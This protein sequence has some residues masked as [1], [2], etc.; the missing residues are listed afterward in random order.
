VNAP[1]DALP[2]WALVAAVI[3]GTLL[4]DECG[5]RLGRRRGRGA[6]TDSVE[7]VGTIVA[8]E[9]GLLAFLLAFSFGIVA[10]RFDA[11]RHMVLDEANAIGTTFLRAEMLPPAER[12][13]V[14]HLLRR[15]AAVRLAATTGAPIDQVLQQSEQIHDQLWRAAVAAAAADARALPTG[16]FIESLNEVIDLHTARV[17]AALR[18]RMPLAVWVVLMA[19]GLLAFFTLGYQAGLT[20]TGRSPATLVLALTFGAVL[21]LVADLDRPGEGFLRVSQEPMVEVQRTMSRVP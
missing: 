18:N 13:S 4:S 8:A 21:W 15:Y 1:L 20:T 7:A 3:A 14:R 16:L 19:V 12:S 11:R 2:L 5:G 10:S 9:L 17:M 6:G